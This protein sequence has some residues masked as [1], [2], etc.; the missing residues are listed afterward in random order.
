[1]LLRLPC[2][3]HLLVQ[4]RRAGQFFWV[5]LLEV[6]VGHELRDRALV[7]ESDL[8]LVLVGVGG[9]L[10]LPVER[11][12]NDDVP[13]R[14]RDV[15]RAGAL[16]RG[17]VVDAG[18]LDGAEELRQV[19]DDRVV[20]FRGV[21]RVLRVV[22]LELAGNVRTGSRGSGGDGRDGGRDGEELHG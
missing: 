22:P 14:R 15:A 8:A 12:A 7:T 20:G 18:V 5:E 13:V 3:Q 17:A 2:L 9:V 16:V 6:V 21:P 4:L 19:L 11:V 10:R 1:M